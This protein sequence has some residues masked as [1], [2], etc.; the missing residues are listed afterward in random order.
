MPTASA[1]H[2]HDGVA[3][4][5]ILVVGSQIGKG[6]EVASYAA[7]AATGPLASEAEGVRLEKA[8][9]DERRARMA[10]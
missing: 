5:L 2:D 1:P 4:S 8:I 6:R 10:S 3:K 9:L 7:R